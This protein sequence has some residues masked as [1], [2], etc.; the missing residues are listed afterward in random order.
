MPRLP[1]PALLLSALCL[2]LPGCSGPRAEAES[3]QGAAG[4]LVVRAG[5]LR[6]RLLLT[7]ELAAG[8]ADDLTVPRTSSWQVQV[9]WLAEEGTAVAAGERV[10]EL[11][12]TQIVSEL[13]EKRLAA[14]Q[15]ADD[16]ARSDAEAA[17]TLEEKRF[18]VEQKQ[19]EV[20]K[21]RIAAAIP[22]GLLAERERQDRQLALERAE[23]ELA[24]AQADLAAHRAASAADLAVLRVELE[25]SRREI[26]AAEQAIDALVLKA[27]RAGIVLAAEHPWEGRKLQEGD[28]VWVGMAVVRLPDL[29]SLEVEAALSDVDD[30][31][32]RPGMAAACTLDAFPGEVFR[33][34]V[35]EVAA[36]AREEDGAASLLRNFQ[37]RLALD[38]VDTRR[39]LPGMSVKVELQEPA[40]RAL[41]APRAG[42][43]L[44]ASPPR[45]RLADGRSVPVQLGACD[46]RAC[47]V[48]SG[49]KDGA[50]LRSTPEDA[51]ANG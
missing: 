24:K 39:M 27:P 47:A 38:R 45:A 14:A 41:L 49:L 36:I 30:G 50:R 28:T 6:P 31:R 18:T 19:S 48:L 3:D 51:E 16:L 17:A 4:E 5:E 13:E 1:A 35:A 33:A 20:D 8:R 12:N 23:I 26:A 2:A 43:D 9:R 21:A 15:K 7:G 11:D 44:A 40:V 22:E 32:V 25:K 46:A 37:V 42:L 29:T 10:A 34:R